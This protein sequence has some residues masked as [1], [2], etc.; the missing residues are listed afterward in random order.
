M[1]RK[2]NI[3]RIRNQGMGVIAYDLNMSQWTLALKKLT[4]F[5]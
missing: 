2:Q 1:V 4:F 3:K 5:P